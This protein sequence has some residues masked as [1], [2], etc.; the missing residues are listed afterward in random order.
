MRD[1]G[2]LGGRRSDANAINALG[3]VTGSAE[4]SNGSRHA[5]LFDGNSMKDLGT[6]GGSRSFGLAIND[7]GWV[8]GF[9]G[10][11][12]DASEH[13]FLWDGIRL[14]DL[15]TLGGLFAEGDAINAA[16]QVAGKSDH[17]R[18]IAEHAFL[19]DGSSMHDLGTLGGSHSFSVAINAAGQVT[20]SADLPGDIIHHAFLWD[21]GTLHD[22]NDLIDPA[23]PL[24]SYVSV[25]V[26]TAIN[27]AGYIVGEG[28]DSRAPADI[29]VYL[30]SPAAPDDL[31]AKNVMT[32]G[33][34]VVR[35]A[36][37]DR[38]ADETRFQIERS[39][40]TNQQCGAF[41]TI[42]SRKENVTIFR[43]TTVSPNTNYCYQLRVIRSTVVHTL[44]NIARIRTIQ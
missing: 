25:D 34:R 15:G 7:S 24:K 32:G 9:A 23:D 43:D 14:R 6:F 30:L 12:N 21:S 16:G 4:V 35:L 27:D 26:G 3:Q 37:S 20:G 5:F 10:T 11:T 39:P 40:V 41:T 1:L 8:T 33:D 28:F 19:W 42:G 36:W 29:R 44:S 22:L 2:T 38:F 31:R 18:R 13:A 17:P